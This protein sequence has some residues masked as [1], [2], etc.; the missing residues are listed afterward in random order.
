M[1]R[2]GG[3]KGKR[4]AE[5]ATGTGKGEGGGKMG[6]IHERKKGGPMLLSL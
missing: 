6:G 3:G 4:V 5:G 2:G 1:W